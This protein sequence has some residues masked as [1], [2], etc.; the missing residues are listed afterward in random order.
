MTYSFKLFNKRNITNNT[1][2]GFT[3]VETLVAVAVLMIAIAGPLSIS[4]K[5]L[6]SALYARDQSIASFLAQEEMEILKNARDNSSTAT[7]QLPANLLLCTQA[8]P[9][10]VDMNNYSGTLGS[11][12]CTT[13]ACQQ[14]YF[15]LSKGY[16]HDNSGS[17]TT[18]SIFSRY[19]YVTTG[20]Q[21]DGVTIE[22][23]DYIATVIVSWNQGTTPNA[24]TL[25]SEL[26]NA[27]R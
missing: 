1:R 17:D 4:N 16:T 2:N 6:T 13:P 23:D 12:S 19:F 15:S 9:C 27:T 22:P 7:G 10:D 11:I 24:I 8:S 21:P 26:V 20:K 25:R 5:A 18:K 3:L 14:L